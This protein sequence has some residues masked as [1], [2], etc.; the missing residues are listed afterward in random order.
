MLSRE[1]EG[2]LATIADFLKSIG[3]AEYAAGLS[4]TGL[5]VSALP[6]LTFRDLDRLGIPPSDREKLL[7]AIAELSSRPQSDSAESTP[8][9]GVERR[10]VTILFCDLVGSTSLSTRLDPEALSEIIYRYRAVCARVISEAGGY[11]AQYLGD[12]VLA[13][14]GYPRASEDDAERA[15]S[16]GLELVE[17]VGEIKDDAGAALQVRVGVASG[18]V[19]IGD[20]MGDN[21]S[22]GRDL[23]GETPNLAGRLQASAAPGAVVISAETRQLVKE[24]FEY[25]PVDVKPLRGDSTPIES[26]RVVRSSDIVDRFRAL[27]TLDVGLVGRARETDSMIARWSEAKTGTG[28]VLLI[29]GEPGI[30]KSRLVQTLLGR[31]KS[32]PHVR[33]RLFCAPNRGGSALYPVISQLQRAANFRPG[34]TAD[35]MLDKVEG[36]LDRRTAHLGEIA[37]LF[38]ELLSV[39]TGSRYPPI[40]LT[41]Q[42]RREKTLQA[43][44]AQI[45]GLSAQPIVMACEDVHWADPT[46]L[47]L[48][49]LVV[50]RA[51]SLPLLL[52]ITFRPEFAPPWLGRPH[53]EHIKLDR[54]PRGESAEMIANLSGDQALSTST[55]EQIID[56]TDGVPLFIEE[57]T[58]VLM[59]RGRA[60]PPL[61]DIPATLRDMLAA[62]LD[63]L[64]QAKEV[65]QIAS[66]LGVEFSGRLLGETMAVD[67]DGLA[68]ELKKLVDA[69][70][71]VHQGPASFADYRFKHALLQ[72]AAYQ[73]L[74]RS[75]RRR[76]HRRAAEALDERF[77]EIVAT[78]PELVALHYA[79]ADMKEPAIVHLRAAAD[80]AMRRSANLEAIGHLGEAL[81]LLLATPETPER[82]QQE[83]ALQLA[84]GTPLVA[85]RGFA[86]PDVGKAYE[87][88]HEICKLSGDAPQLFPVVWG[89]WVFYIACANHAK[90]HELALQCLRIAEAVNDP[91]LV[92][93]ARHA[94][95]V[96][97]T[98]LG[99]F[100]AALAELDQ[101][102][103]LY[104]REKHAPLLYAYGQDSGVVCRS[105][106][107]FCL[108]FLGRS[109]EALKRNEEA[110]ALA[111]ELSHPYSLAAA[112]DFSA[113]V[114]QLAGNPEAAQREAEEALAIST[115]REF[116]FWLLIAMILRGWAL[117]ARD[118][119]EEGVALMRQGLA[120]YEATGAGIMRPYYLALTAQSLARTGAFEE[121]LGL[122][123]QAEAAVQESG[124]RWYES[125]IYRL[126]GRLTLDDAARR[127]EDER[128]RVADDLFERAR[129]IA[130]RQGAAAT[131]LRAAVELCRLWSG[132]DK[133]AEAKARLAEACGRFAP[134]SASPDLEDARALLQA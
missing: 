79:Q 28:R 56:R 75:Q 105:Q 131:E 2:A 35:Q 64:G 76:H 38:A 59:E 17:S 107:A 88:A 109:D 121:A 29:S 114:H 90:A 104:D 116:V 85:T 60:N 1:M 19:L 89:L 13:F 31:L 78:Q 58:K 45:A 106:A 55:V 65:A 91:D 27:R 111:R 39:P 117:S 83:L 15:V 8:A 11:V 124:E 103:A 12:G 14:F 123:D 32:E 10:H 87:R 49:N 50:D 132:D 126:K 47:E 119:A 3:M 98:N 57:L 71:V 4:E 113:W 122:L 120:G 48:L 41:P 127:P 80:S 23:V 22:L 128:R 95:G 43:I 53:V 129:L 61:H 5:D 86:S 70:I 99:R 24:L 108:W 63:R 6:S 21:S 51:P 84:L 102:I 73:S 115:E 100:E 20:L 101:V 7:N 81:K 134:G 62:R 69:G 54:L 52:V 133:A 94:L 33:L 74:V 37:P 125:E 36:M 130:R 34:D 77:P 16:A 118:G 66:V 26:W 92:M 96:S 42:K 97:L 112:L 110:L 68:A 67:A 46:S 93:L 9:G 40:E 44:L 82:L 18:L 25:A 30:G 72:E